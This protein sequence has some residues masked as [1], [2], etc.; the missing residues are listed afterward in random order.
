MAII[1]TSASFARSIFLASL[2]ALGV[3]SLFFIQAPKTVNTSVVGTDM[4]YADTPSCGNNCPPG[5]CTQDSC[6]CGGAGG[7]ASGGCAC[8][9]ACCGACNCDC[10]GV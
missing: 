9:G 4:A 5:S 3:I 8:G 7:C 6:G 2:T 1:Y 10:A